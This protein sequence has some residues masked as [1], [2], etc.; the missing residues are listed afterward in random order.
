MPNIR[1]EKAMKIIDAI[2]EK[3][4]KILRVL[5]NKWKE[6]HQGRLS[7]DAEAYDAVSIYQATG[8]T[9]DQFRSHLENLE[10]IEFLSYD[11]TQVKLLPSGINY[12]LGQFD[13]MRH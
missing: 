13:N 3:D 1:E 5:Y 7:Y 10:H 12:C 4:I 8:L 11:G 6:T 9:K 2:Q